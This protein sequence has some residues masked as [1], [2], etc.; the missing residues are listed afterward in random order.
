[1][2]ALVSFRSSL[3]GMGWQ[4]IQRGLSTAVAVQPSVRLVDHLPPLGNGRI[5]LYLMRHGETDWN[6]K[7]LMQGGG[8][9]IPLNNKGERQAQALK[10][11]FEGLE[12]EVIASSHL[13]RAHGTAEVL[14]KHHQQAK[15]VVS[16]DFG[17]MR[18]GKFEGKEEHGPGQ[19]EA[20]LETIAR[21]ESNPD[22]RFPTEHAEQV[23]ESASAV[24]FRARRGL[25]ALLKEHQ[26]AQH[27]A[28]VAHNRFNKTLMGSLLHRCVFKGQRI[29]QGNTCVN[30]LDLVNG[31]PTSPEFLSCAKWDPIMLNFTEHSDLYEQ[32]A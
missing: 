12:L 10:E 1:M 32:S 4:R 7:G 8:F 13:R 2:S 25:Q 23:G 9:D 5:R 28:V 24:A 22:Y 16:L 30:V 31:D 11:A 27:I 19:K 29:V 20:I 15:S 17:E 14:L 6:A 26:D 21:W 18:F 3:R